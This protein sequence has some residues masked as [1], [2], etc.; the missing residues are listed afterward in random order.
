[1]KGVVHDPIM[2]TD[3]N[4]ALTSTGICP[5]AESLAI[6]AGTAI[7]SEEGWLKSTCMILISSHVTE[8]TGLLRNPLSFRLRSGH[9]KVKGCSYW[10]LERLI[11]PLN[12]FLL[13]TYSSRPNLRRPVF[14]S[15]TQYHPFLPAALTFRSP[16]TLGDG[17]RNPRAGS[18]KR[19][20]SESQMQQQQQL[21][22]FSSVRPASDQKFCLGG[23]KCSSCSP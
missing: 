1:M 17:P 12:I 20:Q 6:L 22:A 2:A 21:A 13:T 8:R 16:D 3:V 5:V 11:S 14:H 9:R 19:L 10:N 18:M 15:T 7:L 4:A 23:G